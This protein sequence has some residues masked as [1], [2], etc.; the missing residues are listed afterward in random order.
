MSKYRIDKMAFEK[1]D[2]WDHL[3]DNSSNGTI[4]HKLGFLSYHMVKF[5]FHFIG[6]EDNSGLVAVV[7]GGVI[8]QRYVTPCGASYGGMVHR[9]ESLENLIEINKLWLSYCK[10][11]GLQGIDI[12]LSPIIYN[13]QNS[14]IDQYALESVGFKNLSSP[15]TSVIDIPLSQNGDQLTMYDSSAR[16]AI[17]KAQRSK[18]EV[19]YNSPSDSFYK[20][21]IKN[22]A[23]N[24][25][26]PV[27]L[28]KEILWLCDKFK[29]KIFFLNA[30]LGEREIA[31]LLL[32]QCNRRV[33]L[34]FYIYTD[35][36]F[37][38][39]R[40]TDLLIH[41]AIVLASS[42]EI[43]YFDLGVSEEVVD[44][45]LQPSLSLFRFKMKYANRLLLRPKLMIDL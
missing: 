22:K 2:E 13:Q 37:Q 45:K 38:E 3:C 29:D 28:K 43:P 41:N 1:K 6:I 24:G 5:P 4:F 9:E 23:R 44:R 26:Q 42:R 34:A 12:T 16:R 11:Q 32:F 36:E 18:I 21:L 40:P 19:R 8:N 39:F 30:Y 27:H 15:A 35:Y 10:N 33:L 17:K 25:S 20:I 7:P 31:G 14:Q